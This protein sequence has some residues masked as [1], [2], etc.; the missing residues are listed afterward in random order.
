M[1]SST[2]SVT[3]QIIWTVADETNSD[4]LDLPALHDAVDPDSLEM[5]IEGMSEGAIAFTYADRSITVRADGVVD[6]EESPPA[7]D[8]PV[9]AEVGD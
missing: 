5:L 3:A 9:S 4:P 7:V 2:E 1:P 6:V 8:A